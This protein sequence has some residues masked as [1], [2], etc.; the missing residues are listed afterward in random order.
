MY[1]HDCLHQS[2]DF[3]QSAQQSILRANLATEQPFFPFYNSM[4]Y[5]ATLQ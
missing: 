5:I 1:A 3:R 2:R 4:G